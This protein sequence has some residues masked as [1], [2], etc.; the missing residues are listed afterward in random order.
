MAQNFV[1]NPFTGALDTIDTVTVAP[2]GAT[3]NANA[4][5]VTGDNVLTLQPVSASFPGVL[6][7]A[8]YSSFLAASA[9]VNG[10]Y[11]VNEVLASPASGGPGALSV[12]SLVSAD[13][14]NL[15]GIYVTQSEVGAPNGVAP[16]DGSGKVPYANLPSALMTFKGAW[17]PTTNTPTLTN[18]TGLTGDTYRASVGGTSTAPIADTWFAGDFI[19]YNGT[20]WQ[21]SP[22]A[23]GVISVNGLSGA[24]TVNAINQLTGDVT[25]G[26]ASGSQSQVATIANA[27]VTLAKMANLPANT[28]IGN[29]TGISA[30]PLAL[31][32]TQVTA[33]LNLFTS[34]LQGLVP[35]SG[36]GTTN[37]LRADGT[38]A[39]PPGSGG[40][41]TS[42][43]LAD[44]TGTFNI[45]GSP[46]TTSGTLTLA[47]YASQAAKTFLAAPNGSSGAPTF[48][49]IVPA[50][51]PTLNQNTTGTAANITATSNSTLTTLTAL[52]LPTSQLSGTISLTT[53]VSGVLPIANG[54]T[55][56]GTLPVTA[57]GVIYTDGTKFQN[58]GAGTTGQILTSQG[59][60]API[61]TTPVAAA[62]YNG[63][64]NGAFDWWQ[65]GTSVTI[66]NTVSTYQ[67]DQWYGKNSLGTNGV[68]TLSQTTGSLNGSL[69]GAQLKITTAPTAAQTNGTELYQV[70]SNKAMQPYYNQT[71]SFTVSV[72]A[73]NNV[74]QVGVQFYYAT[75]EVKLTTAIGSEI[76]TTVNSSTFTSCTIN[77]Q[78]L[79]TAMTTAGVIGVRIR[80]T[81]V[82][83]GNTYDLNNGFICEQ[84]TVVLGSSAPTFARQFNDPVQEFSACEFF[85]EKTYDPT[86]NPGTVSSNGALVGMSAGT[87]FF[88]N[89]N[90]RVSKRV[91]GT[92][93]YYSNATGTAGDIRNITNAVDVAATIDFNG[94]NGNS[95]TATVPDNS[96]VGWQSVC[97]SR[98]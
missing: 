71:A 97:D 52:S 38:F 33:M 91:A 80:I 12:R 82:S 16:L 79:G 11:A 44:S 51:V 47:S 90:Y 68:L 67:P 85:Y 40:T 20:I 27:A 37:F 8:D 4:A 84:A 89:V 25:A 48:R 30:T 96:L 87:T 49:L 55:D 74:T 76:L 26:P 75:S 83:T 59:A 22:L 15:S 64:V 86:V 41:V 18:G 21:R 13:I 92:V 69:F 77:G 24:V 42:V 6:D 62:V 32:T 23:D 81:A 56:N 54:G 72:K 2:V 61:W 73:T 3:P 58:S 43:A 35:A 19:I 36:G 7:S 14:P 95:F 45:S 9:V 34:S 1:F 17:N 28:I 60:S 31:T 93:T 29:N 39:T 57:G 63:L 5:T 50:D 98:I 70:L 10:T 88:A 94:I 78:A 65:A 46:V 66:A 53:Q